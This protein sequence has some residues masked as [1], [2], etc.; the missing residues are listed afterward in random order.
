MISAN[1]K[2]HKRGELKLQQMKEVT[3]IKPIL[4]QAQKQV[5]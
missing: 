1:K 5:F 4:T 2:L 3:H